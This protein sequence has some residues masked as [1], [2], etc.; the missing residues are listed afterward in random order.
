MMPPPE[1]LAGWAKLR[2]RRRTGGN[3]TYMYS[4][5]RSGRYTSR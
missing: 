3:V 2:W 4:T 1:D 5:S